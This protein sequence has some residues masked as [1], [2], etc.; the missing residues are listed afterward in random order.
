LSI[1]LFSSIRLSWFSPLPCQCDWKKNSFCRM[2]ADAVS[3]SGL[4]ILRCGTHKFFY[5]RMIEMNLFCITTSSVGFPN[6]QI[7][8]QWQM[9]WRRKQL[10]VVSITLYCANVGTIPSWQPANQVGLHTILT[11]PYSFIGKRCLSLVVIKVLILYTWLWLI[12]CFVG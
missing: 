3:S 5:F 4:M 10:L 6:H 7:N 1:Q 9:S 2:R 12:I 11:L 8:L